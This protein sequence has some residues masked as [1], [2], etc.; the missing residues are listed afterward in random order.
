[1]SKN[2]RVIKAPAVVSQRCSDVHIPK[3]VDP[4]KLPGKCNITGSID[5]ALSCV[6]KLLGTFDEYDKAPTLATP[7]ERAFSKCTS[8]FNSLTNARKCLEEG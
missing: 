5:T 3:V 6:E 1:M 7:R 8:A 4:V 2:K